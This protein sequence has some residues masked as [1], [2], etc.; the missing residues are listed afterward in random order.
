[1]SEAAAAGS[2]AV[3][4]LAPFSAV[5]EASVTQSMLSQYRAVSRACVRCGGQSGIGGG[6]LPEA[7][8]PVQRATASSEGSIAINPRAACFWPTMPRNLTLRPI[9]RLFLDELKV[10]D[11]LEALRR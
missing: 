7:V 8:L 1:M 5:I 10:M 2:A 11:H 6:W 9:C 3:D 4:A